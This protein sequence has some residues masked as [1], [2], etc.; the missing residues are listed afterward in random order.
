[1][2]TLKLIAAIL[3]CIGATTFL[4]MVY[5]VGISWMYLKHRPIKESNNFPIR[6]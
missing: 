1:M 3:V 5:L 6:H 4:G 2:N